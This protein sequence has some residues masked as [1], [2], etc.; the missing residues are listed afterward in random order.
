MEYILKNYKLI[1]SLNSKGGVLTSIK[2]N[3]GLEYLWQGDESYWS[4]QAPVLFPICGSLT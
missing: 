1:V 2:N 3:E 4:G